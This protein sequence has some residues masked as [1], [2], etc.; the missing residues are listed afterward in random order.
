ML[1]CATQDVA[2]NAVAKDRGNDVIFS[3]DEKMTSLPRSLAKREGALVERLCVPRLQLSEMG[4]YG[5]S[6]CFQKKI[7]KYISSKVS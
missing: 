6:V 7:N 5:L 1:D 2:S 4:S 3:S